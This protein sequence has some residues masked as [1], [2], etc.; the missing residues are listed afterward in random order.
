MNIT[1]VCKGG[2]NTGLGH[3]HRAISFIEG[4]EGHAVF[5]VIAIMDKGLETLFKNIPDVTF[6][7]DEADLPKVINQEKF[8]SACCI[9][10]T[11][12]LSAANQQVLRS[13]YEKIISLS[14]VFNNYDIVDVVFTR[15]S[16]YNYP[17]HIR[18]FSG[19]EYF[20]FNTNCIQISDEIY[21]RN[22]S[23]KQLTIGISMGGVDAPNKTFK[24]LESLSKLEQEYT[25]WVLLGEGYSHSYQDLVESIR[26]DSNHEIVLAKSNRSMWKILSNC[27]LAIF[28]GG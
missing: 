9:I 22:L 23:E 24:I 20:I 14:P 2:A 7:Y 10:D 11:V 21:N 5:H 28:A 1:L 8:N 4:A 25:F 6:I 12:E 27:S 18:V 3:L 19:L 16:E 15:F 26:R 17:D 13:R